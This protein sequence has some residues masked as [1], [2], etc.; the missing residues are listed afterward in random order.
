[1]AARLIGKS[2]AK[3]QVQGLIDL[4]C[5]DSTLRKEAADALK[6][7]GE[8][9][10]SGAVSGFEDDPVRLGK[11]G[12]KRVL[13]AMSKA[14]MAST[15]KSERLN[16]AKGLVALQK[17]SGAKGLLS[18]AIAKVLRTPHTDSWS[19]SSSDCSTRTHSD[20]GGFDQGAF[21]F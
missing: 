11:L 3:D 21:D 14:L 4:L 2:G 12:D 5:S 20:N 13:E 15:D 7:L 8:A 19:G 1:L 18:D 16:L 9:S 17:S 10:W 6:E